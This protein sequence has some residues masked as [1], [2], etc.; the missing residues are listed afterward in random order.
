MFRAGAYVA[1]PKFP[2]RIGLE[3]SGVIDAVGPGVTDFAI[4][5]RA[6]TVPY[7]SWDKWDQSARGFN[8]MGAIAESW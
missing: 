4:G 1:S 5:D 6:A 7:L 3:A 2:S 8:Q